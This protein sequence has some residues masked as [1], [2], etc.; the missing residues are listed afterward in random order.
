VDILSDYDGGADI[1]VLGN[2]FAAQYRGSGYAF[3]QGFSAAEG[4]K[5]KVFGS[6][7]DY[8]VIAVDDFY[9]DYEIFYQG[10]LLAQVKSVIAIDPSSD[11]ISAEFLQPTYIA[12]A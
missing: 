12:Q 11:F 6:I 9:Y 10:D 2:R 4:D 3:I 8:Q 7:D 5:I 1:F